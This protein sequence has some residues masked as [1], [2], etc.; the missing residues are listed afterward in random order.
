[1]R[2]AWYTRLGPAAEVLTLGETDT[3][4]PGP[5]EVLVRVAASGINPSDT[6]KRA[7]W[8]GG[9]LEFPRII[10]HSDG[11][12]TIESVGAGVDAARV[13]ERV[14]IYNAQYGRADGTAAEYVTLPAEMVVSLPDGTSFTEGACLGVPA[15]TAHYVLFWDNATSLAGKTVLVQGGAGAV[16]GYAV[17]MAAL[18]GA[19]VIATISSPEKAEIARGY[20]AETTID[21]RSEDVTEAVMQATGGHGVD[22]IVEVDLG[23]NAAID[24]AVLAP[25]GAIG[26]YSSTRAPKFE[27][28]Y[29]GF[30]YKGARIA[31]SQVYILTPEE[32]ARAVADLTRWMAAGELRHAVAEVFPLAQIAAAHAAVETGGVVGNVVVEV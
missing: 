22:H 29:Y 7:G 32:R 16:G 18:S 11:A 4:S 30:G 19:R 5:G 13:G 23:A 27:F 6:K 10:P 20:G 12:G 21:Y 25:R 3:P 17:Q 26:A 1:M 15:C 14:W 24:A 28:D 9:T 2:A 8:L 31:F